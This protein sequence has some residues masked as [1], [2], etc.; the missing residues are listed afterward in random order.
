M[1][2][3]HEGDKYIILIVLQVLIVITSYVLKFFQPVAS[4]IF[5]PIITVLSI[6]CS[7][8]HSPINETYIFMKQQIFIGQA[9]YAL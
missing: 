4:Q 7:L 8:R 1:L 3:V 5:E 9:L 6:P 2:E